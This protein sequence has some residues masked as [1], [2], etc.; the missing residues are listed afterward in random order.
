MRF[1]VALLEMQ[2]LDQ[3]NLAVKGGPF[4]LRPAPSQANLLCYFRPPTSLVCVPGCLRSSTITEL[5]TGVC[6]PKRRGFRVLD[7]RSDR[8]EW[9]AF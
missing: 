3:R 9:G 5:F 8:A 2:M 1:Q 7:F 4:D 6:V